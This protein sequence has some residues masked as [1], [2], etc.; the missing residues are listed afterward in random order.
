MHPHLNHVR[1]HREHKRA[2]KTPSC[3]PHPTRIQLPAQPNRDSGILGPHPLENNRLIRRV[4]AP[5]HVHSTL[6]PD[7]GFLHEREGY[8]LLALR[9]SLDSFPT[10]DA[11]LRCHQLQ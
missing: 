8:T 3:S 7:A 1:L 5:S 11:H 10:L 9:K 6:F 2:Q 4:D